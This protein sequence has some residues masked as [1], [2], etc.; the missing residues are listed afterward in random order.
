MQEMNILSTP[1]LK[2]KEER[3]ELL[4][5]EIHAWNPDPVHGEKLAGCGQQNLARKSGSLV[6]ASREAWAEMR[7]LTSGKNK[8]RLRPGEQVTL[9][10]KHA[11]TLERHQLCEPRPTQ[12]HTKKA[13]NRE[14]ENG[15]RL[16]NRIAQDRFNKERF[17]H[18]TQ[19]FLQP[20][21]EFMTHF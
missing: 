8:T 2:S 13:N 17:F 11:R 10:S 19:R 5:Q 9:R 6:P 12:Q 7:E 3:Y 16:G 18:A 15:S 1:K 4:N 14:Q 21:H 20:N